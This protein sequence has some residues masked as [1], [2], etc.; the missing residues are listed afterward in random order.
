MAFITKIIKNIE[1]KLEFE[2]VISDE[3]LGNNF[4]V[5][6]DVIVSQVIN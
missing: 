1:N 3:K 5:T 2:I 6:P 4:V